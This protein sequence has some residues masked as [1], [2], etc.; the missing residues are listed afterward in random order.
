MNETQVLAIQPSEALGMHMLNTDTYYAHVWLQF[1][2]RDCYPHHLGYTIVHGVSFSKPGL[3]GSPFSTS[4]TGLY[5]KTAD[6][7]LS[8]YQAFVYITWQLSPLAPNE[9][10]TR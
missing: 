5:L 7:C 3:G 9:L 10:W 1:S 2:H 6:L 4:L 8:I